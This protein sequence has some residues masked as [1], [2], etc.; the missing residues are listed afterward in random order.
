MELT[1]AA[2]NKMLKALEDE[3]AST[4]ARNPDRERSGFFYSRLRKVSSSISY[5]LII[6]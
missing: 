5:I 1:S 3:K 2:A 4:N 6:N